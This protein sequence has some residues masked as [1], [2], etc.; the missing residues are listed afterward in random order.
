MPSPSVSAPATMEGVSDSPRG[1]VLVV[2]DEPT[3][4]EV[5]GRYMERA[6]YET[7]GAGEPQRLGAVAGLYRPDLVV[8]DV[9]LPGFDGIEVMRQLHEGPGERTAVILLT[10]VRSP[11][12]SC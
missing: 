2:D 3:I 7:H 9:M 8:L 4:V 5:V 10:A 6:G 1:T 12:P 11:G